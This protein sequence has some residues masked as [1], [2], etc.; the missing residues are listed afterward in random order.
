MISSGTYQRQGRNQ[1]ALW[2]VLIMIRTFATG[3]YFINRLY[4]S[5]FQHE[6]KKEQTLHSSAL[7]VLTKYCLPD[8]SV[9]FFFSISVIQGGVCDLQP[10]LLSQFMQKPFF[11]FT[12][13]LLLVP[14]VYNTSFQLKTKKCRGYTGKES[15]RIYVREVNTLLN[16]PFKLII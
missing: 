8:M 9:M 3:Y 12:M 4:S 2:P 16:M 6:R 13:Q 10:C 7:F 11:G 14:S 15:Q 5:I 1:P